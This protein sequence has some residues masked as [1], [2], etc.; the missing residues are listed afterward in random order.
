MNK[1]QEKSGVD[2]EELQASIAGIL[3][4]A[5]TS[6]TFDGAALTKYYSAAGKTIP[7]CDVLE[8]HRLVDEKALHL[9][10]ERLQTIEGEK[11]VRR[12]L[13]SAPLRAQVRRWLR[14]HAPTVPVFETI[15]HRS[16]QGLQ[17]DHPIVGRKTVVRHGC[18]RTAS[19][20]EQHVYPLSSSGNLR[21][22]N[23]APINAQTPHDTFGFL[24]R[25]GSK[26]WG[27]F[28][29]EDHYCRI[30]AEADTPS[31]VS[32]GGFRTDVHVTEGDFIFRGTSSVDPLGG[33]FFFSEG[34][35]R[36]RFVVQ[37]H[38]DLRG[39]AVDPQETGHTASLELLSFPFGTE[40][41][42]R[43]GVFTDP[44]YNPPLPLAVNASVLGPGTIRAKELINYYIFLEDFESGGHARFTL[45]AGR[46][47]TF[48]W[49]VIRPDSFAEIAMVAEE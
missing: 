7:W 40:A 43:Y 11:A 5:A 20:W 2:G 37:A 31:V 41:G 8:Q 19:S 45:F 16:Q 42:A 26:S 39:D 47:D 46:F 15:W 44:N 25:D 6:G 3:R 36:G 38:L 48:C 4:A 33:F 9:W 22:E 28:E 1:D 10:R 13:E 27:G 18:D 32:V 21:P 30:D 24:H 23:A 12:Y 29:R 34:V 17:L 14:R 35:R 49:E